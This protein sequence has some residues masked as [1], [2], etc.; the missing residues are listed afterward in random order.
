VTSGTSNPLSAFENRHLS[1]LPSLAELRQKATSMFVKTPSIDAI[2]QKGH[3][4]LLASV[5]ERL[6]DRAAA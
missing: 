6:R 2:V 5:G 4:L 3:A 1:E